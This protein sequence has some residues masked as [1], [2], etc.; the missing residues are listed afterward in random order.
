VP[1]RDPEEICSLFKQ[2][3]A[4]GDVDGLLSVYD[5]EVV[6]L[7]EAG[8]VVKGKQE[9]KQQLAPFASARARFDFQVKQIIQ[10]GDI[11]LMHT[12]WNISSPRRLSTYA[13]EVARR[14]PDGT[15]CWLISDPFTVGRQ[16]AATTAALHTR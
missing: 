1:A 13:I 4:E 5:P 9:M 7:N 10:S 6:F 15:W 14:Q 2:F 3:M 16:S 8:A 11:A 12:M